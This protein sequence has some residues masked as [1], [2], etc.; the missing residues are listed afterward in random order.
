[1]R[2]P[3]R[4]VARWGDHADGIRWIL[5]LECGHEVTRRKRYR[6]QFDVNGGPRREIDPAPTWAYCEVC[7]VNG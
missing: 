2:G 3:K 4:K 7:N 6:N 1:M 5:S